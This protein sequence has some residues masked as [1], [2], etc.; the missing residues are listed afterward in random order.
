MR[1]IQLDRRELQ[2]II[3]AAARANR[4]QDNA[5]R[6][7]YG[8]PTEI[9]R[10]N[11]KAKFNDQVRVSPYTGSDIV[12]SLPAVRRE[13]IGK[14]ITVSNITSVKNEIIVL[15]SPG[16]TID[17]YRNIVMTQT[18]DTLLLIPVTETLWLSKV[19]SVTA[20]PANV[21]K[22]TDNF[23]GDT[24]D[25][26]RWAADDE[27]GS[28]GLDGLGHMQIQVPA[29]TTGDWWSNA[30]G[31]PHAHFRP[32]VGL[33]PHVGVLYGELKAID[34]SMGGANA[35][36]GLA[37]MSKSKYSVGQNVRGYFCSFNPAAGTVSW[38]EVGTSTALGQE[39][40]VS[41]PTFATPHY[42]RIYVN[43]SGAERDITIGSV[44]VTMEAGTVWS[45]WSVDGGSTWFNT[46]ISAVNSKH[47]PTIKSG[48]VTWGDMT[49][50]FC[51]FIKVWSSYG[52]PSTVLYDSFTSEVF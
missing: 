29:G 46:P 36:F 10:S 26:A 21:T 47:F 1:K 32:Q 8:F 13:D 41:A 49:F 5:P 44:S 19:S 9:I 42:Y 22:Y 34:S 35:E 11:Y 51:P 50:S 24:I 20:T 28:V 48:T 6:Y 12:I 39:T 17:G 14:P 30:S 25:S 15:A 23:S 37:I 27:N 40:S 38:I 3:D 4:E 52:S 16:A 31:A 33:A 2:Y 7:F 18:Y 43:A 45:T